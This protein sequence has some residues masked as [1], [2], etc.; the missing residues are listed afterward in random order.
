MALLIRVWRH[1]NGIATR[2][3]EAVWYCFSG[4]CVCVCSCVCVSIRELLKLIMT[5]YTVSQKKHLRCF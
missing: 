1:R 3:D 4:V 2:A 5:N